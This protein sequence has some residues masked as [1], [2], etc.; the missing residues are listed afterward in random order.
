MKRIDSR[1]ASSCFAFTGFDVDPGDAA[2]VGQRQVMLDVPVRAEDEGLRGQPRRQM[3]GVLRGQA[4]QPGQPVLAGDPQHAV[5]RP[6]HH[7][8]RP[9]QRPLLRERV[10]VVRGDPRVGPLRRDGSR[11]GQQR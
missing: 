1:K 5:M 2:V 6:V 8:R 4:V 3:L 10:T 9:G 11:G 7:A